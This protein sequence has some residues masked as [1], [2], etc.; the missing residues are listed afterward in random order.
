MSG[1]TFNSA[2]LGINAA[3]FLNAANIQTSLDQVATALNTIRSQSQTFGNNLSVIQTRQD[4]TKNLVDILKTGSDQLVLADKNE[5]GAN[6]LALQTAQQLGI[7]A[8]ALASQ[9][10][11][12][13]L[14]LFQ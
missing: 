1:V 4:F 6:L 13:V 14:R 9:A 5:E 3:D 11:Q 10:N 8:L 12:S 7:Q 2:T